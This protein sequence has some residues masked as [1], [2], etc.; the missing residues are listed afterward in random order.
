[1]IIGNKTFDTKH[2]TESSH[3]RSLGH[4]ISQMD[5]KSNTRFAGNRH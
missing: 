3:S 4:K 1:M 2:H 5:T